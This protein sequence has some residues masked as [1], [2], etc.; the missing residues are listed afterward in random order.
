M[1]ILHII[2]SLKLGGGET[3]L[4]RFLAQSTQDTRYKHVVAYFYPGP[5]VQAIKDLGVPVHH[6]SGLFLRYDFVALY[7]VM[8]LINSFKPD[9]IHSSLWS[10]NIIARLLAWH[11]QLPLVCDL[12]GNAAHEG[13]L[14]NVLDRLTAT[15]PKKI[16]AVADGVKKAYEKTIVG[17]LRA[18]Q[19]QA[20][21]A[22][23]LAV[24]KNG[25]DVCAIR[26]YAQQQSLA[27]SDFGLHEHD[28]V[29]GSVGRLDAIKSYDV[30]VKAFALLLKN[31]QSAGRP[32]KLCLV[33]GG[34]DEEKIK[35]LVQQLGI[36]QHIVLA[37]P[38]SDGARFYKLFD[39]FALSSQSEGL[40]IALLEAMA[41]GLPVVST[42]AGTH[43]VLVDGSNGFLVPVNDEQA[44]AAALLRLYYNPALAYAMGLANR[45]L[46]EQDYTLEKMVTSYHQLYNEL[47]QAA[48]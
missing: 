47:V 2:T 12:H 45:T 9:I 48:S 23:S 10:A 36:A 39:C 3:M 46:V 38:R 15:I 28:F 11:Y 18:P 26:A 1:K 42:C 5:F 13:S 34:Q 6:I 21:V 25:I 43:E 44:L 24:I 41:F 20:R 27:R 16:V 7:Q 17:A 14:R 4:Y 40:S 35:T 19:A 31:V 32:V 29:V 33:G 30:L 37:G 22:A 8:R